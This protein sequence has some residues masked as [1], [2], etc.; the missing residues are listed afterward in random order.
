MQLMYETQDTASDIWRN[1]VMRVSAVKQ[2]KRKLEW[3][4]I[5]MIQE[6]LDVLPGT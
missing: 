4:T 1:I 5:N 3:F 2:N 6:K